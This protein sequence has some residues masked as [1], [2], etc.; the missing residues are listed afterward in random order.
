MCAALLALAAVFGAG[1]LAVY[2]QTAAVTADPNPVT[3]DADA[4]RTQIAWDTGDGSV[5]QVCVSVDGGPEA[6]FAV[7]ARGS[8]EA[9]WI[10]AGK[11]YEFRLYRGAERAE[12]LGSVVV[13]NKYEWIDPGGTALLVVLAAL[14]LGGYF[15]SGTLRRRLSGSPTAGRLGE[16]IRS[17]DPSYGSALY[18]FTL[19]RLVVV[20]VFL[21]TVNLVLKEPE[22]AGQ[23]REASITVADRGHVGK[24]GQMALIN[25]AGWYMTIVRDG[26]ERRPFDT[27]R[28]A[29]WA[30]FPL[31]PLLWR[32]ASR[33]TG[34]LP[35]TGMALS[36]IFFFFAL[37]MLHRLV[38]QFGHAADVADRTVFYV[39]AFPSSYF[40]SL[41]WTESLFLCLS[42]GAF[43]AAKRGSWWLAGAAGAL[44]TA[45]RVSGVYLFP[46][47]LILYLQQHGRRVRPNVLALLLIPTGALAFMSYLYAITGNALAFR[48]ILATWARHSGF[49]LNPLVAYLVR[50]SE[51]GVPWDL[52]LLNFT[53]AV[54]ALACTFV[55]FKRRQW[56]LGLYALFSALTPL[57]TGI[58]MSFTRYTAVAFPVH[59]ALASAGRR[60]RVDQAIRALF[61][62][63]L[64]LMSALFA[65]NITLG[66]A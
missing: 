12:V 49:F 51:V 24:V 48:D 37:V 22:V 59:M 57:S 61:V 42:V 15:L 63:A 54:V 20:V 45:T 66:G 18:A 5:G 55:L 7:G 23:P 25:D 53:V 43:Y 9:P 32:Y 30:F 39:A 58:L 62:A 8:Q 11:T 16:R 40:F 50:P 10:T 27:S 21:L 38:R 36:N 13:R 26:Y 14:L 47:L 4:G 60:P 34:E 31:Y 17:L 2:A 28:Q 52:K 6:L 1:R 44:S 29:N 19:T 33:L 3:S 41:P 56:A 46:V 64:A 65:A 35:F